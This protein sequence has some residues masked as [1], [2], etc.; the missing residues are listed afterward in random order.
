MNI[1][2]SFTEEL[3][4]LINKGQEFI[5]RMNNK[6]MNIGEI[7]ISKLR[8]NYDTL[9]YVSIPNM[10]EIP[11]LNIIGP[12]PRFLMTTRNILK[13]LDEEID[14]GIVNKE[15]L[16]NLYI[17]AKLY[18]GMLEKRK[19]EGKTPYG[20]LKPLKMAIVKLEKM[21]NFEIKTEELQKPMDID[22]MLTED[23]VN[24]NDSSKIYLKETL[25]MHEKYMKSIVSEDEINNPQVLTND[26]IIRLMKQEESRNILGYNSTKM[27]KEKIQEI[28]ERSKT[29]LKESQLDDN[30]LQLTV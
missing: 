12:V 30:N 16:E 10:V 5:N 24:V 27:T 2:D 23:S 17:L 28:A 22:R 20:Y 4:G 8:F 14:I 21:M 29:G 25:D 18:N 7:D 26:Q 13:Y 6:I 11:E 9:I 15:H 3:K 19:Q 1:V